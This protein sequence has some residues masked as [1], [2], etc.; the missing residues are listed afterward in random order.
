MSEH[1]EQVV[2]TKEVEF[3][4]VTFIGY[5]RS[6]GQV[7]YS[8]RK[9]VEALEIPI[10][11]FGKIRDNL[12]ANPELKNFNLNKKPVTSITVVSG[13]RQAILAHGNTQYQILDNFKNKT[14]GIS[15]SELICWMLALAETG[16]TKWKA[17]ADAGLAILFEMAEDKAFDK[18]K[19]VDEY[20]IEAVALQ[21]VIQEKRE[22][23]RKISGLRTNKRLACHVY[24]PNNELIYGGQTRDTYDKP[25]AAIKHQ[26]N[27]GTEML[28]GYIKS[29]GKSIK[30]V[31]SESHDYI[32]EE[33]KDLI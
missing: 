17:V 23:L 8:E 13:L 25:D 11:S 1:I 27:I 28:Q 21:K 26:L 29:K 16:D 4:G 10:S 3:F 9:A 19:T 12:I 2:E 6:N 15:K 5:M 32:K 14:T 33:Y 31:I 18:R 30:E 22:E 24:T 7:V 20:Q